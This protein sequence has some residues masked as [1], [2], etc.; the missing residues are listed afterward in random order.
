MAEQTVRVS[1]NEMKVTKGV[2]HVTSRTVVGNPVMQAEPAVFA[3]R[4]F[5]E[6]LDRVSQ[7]AKTPKRAS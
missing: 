4:D 2:G 6:A 1:A 7:P 3:R 5:E